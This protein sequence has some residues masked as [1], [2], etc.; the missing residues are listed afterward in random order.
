MK[1]LST[2]SSSSSAFLRLLFQA[3][4]RACIH[5]M[6][7]ERVCFKNMLVKKSVAADQVDAAMIMEVTLSDQQQSSVKLESGSR[8]VK[9]KA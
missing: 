9:L 3:W 8:K 4:V 1:S 7:T 5:W 6:S 2:S